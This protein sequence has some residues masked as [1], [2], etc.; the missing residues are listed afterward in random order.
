MLQHYLFTDKYQ[1]DLKY[2]DKW[3]KSNSMAVILNRVLV[4]VKLKRQNAMP[5][6]T[7]ALNAQIC[8]TGGFLIM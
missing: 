1:V 3:T 5:V 4:I 2:E 6:Y 7:Y 8:G